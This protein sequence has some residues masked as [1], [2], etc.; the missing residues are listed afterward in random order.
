MDGDFTAVDMVVRVC[1]AVHLVGIESAEAFGNGGSS[2]WQYPGWRTVFPKKQ[3]AI[4]RFDGLVFS[5]AIAVDRRLCVGRNE[6]RHGISFIYFRDFCGAAGFCVFQGSGA[7]DDVCGA[8]F[9][10]APSLSS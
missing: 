10:G 5:A 4:D 1:G 3:R 2:I 8:R 6:P 7:D 9:W